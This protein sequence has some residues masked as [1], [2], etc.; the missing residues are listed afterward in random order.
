MSLAEKFPLSPEDYLQGEAS[1]DFKHE[2]MAGEVWAMVGASDA[3]VTIAGNLFF[4]LKQAFKNSPC[5]VYISDMK[6]RVEKAD[7]FFYP[8]VLVSCDGKDRDNKLYKQYPSFIAEV[9]SPST[10]A[11]DRGEKFKA[12]RQLDSLQHYWLIDSKRMLIDSFTRQDNND[13]LLHSYSDAEEI[14]TLPALA[15]TCSL[16]DI[17]EDV[18]FDITDE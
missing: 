11:F 15:L 1:A 5:R 6:V 7:A 13:W 3:H 4:I 8:D 2:F 18:L 17:Y 10:E 9:L 14:I 16:S 12:Y